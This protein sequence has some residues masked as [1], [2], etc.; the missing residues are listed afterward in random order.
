MAVAGET[1]PAQKVVR[2]DDG[3][4]YS[5]HTE[6]RPSSVLTGYEDAATLL[7]SG[8]SVW[9][10]SDERGLLEEKLGRRVWPIQLGRLGAMSHKV[11]EWEYEPNGLEVGLRVM[12]LGKDENGNDK[13]MTSTW[14]N[15]GGLK[16]IASYEEYLDP[17]GELPNEVGL[18]RIGLEQIYQQLDYWANMVAEALEFG[19][20]GW[21]ETLEIDTEKMLM[22]KGDADDAGN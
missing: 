7:W 10:R 2:M 6:N 1:A 22:R 12:Y 13:F 11:F 4:F 17:D 21:Q 19:D 15:P 16:D 3:H 8:V 14:I 20:E 5:L 18:R 9:I